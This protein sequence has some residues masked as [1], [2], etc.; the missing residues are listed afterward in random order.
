MVAICRKSPGTSTIRSAPGR[1]RYPESNASPRSW[2]GFYLS[3]S[4]DG[5]HEPGVLTLYFRLFKCQPGGDARG[6]RNQSLDRRR[7]IIT[8]GNPRVGRRS[9]RNDAGGRVY[10]RAEFKSMLSLDHAAPEDN[11][12][13]ASLRK[14]SS[15]TGVQTLETHAISASPCHVFAVWRAVDLTMECLS[16]QPV[17]S[18][19]A[20]VMWFR[21]R[22]GTD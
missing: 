8:V 6:R 12:G 17:G 9:D 4:D 11:R 2:N 16:K 13:G 15:C 5:P 7:I 22:R 14:T 3:V 1:F 18:P 19:D 10:P 20:T 21:A